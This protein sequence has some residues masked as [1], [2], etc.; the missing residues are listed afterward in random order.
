M[1]NMKMVIEILSWGGDSQL[2][3]CT[4]LLSRYPIGMKL[5]VGM[6]EIDTFRLKKS[7]TKN[8]VWALRNLDFRER[9]WFFMFKFSGFSMEKF[10]PVKGENQD[11]PH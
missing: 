10:V 5:A 11:S 7:V 8:I 9:I 4:F 3:A 1:Y 2:L 6:E